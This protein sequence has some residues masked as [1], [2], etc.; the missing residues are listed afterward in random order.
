MEKT[1]EWFLTQGVLGVMCLVL[2]A[3]IAWTVRAWMSERRDCD[4]E[5]KALHEAHKA[6]M[7]ENGK[8]LL[9]VTERT[10]GAIDRLAELEERRRP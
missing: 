5:K 9:S 6:E 1:S 8:A 7:R 10:L 3:A 4:A 2:M